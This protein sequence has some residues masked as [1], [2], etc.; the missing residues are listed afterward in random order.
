MSPIG[1]GSRD[2][3]SFPEVDDYYTMS[4]VTIYI[5]TKAIRQYTIVE[6]NTSYDGHGK[7]I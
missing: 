2:T 3:I 6:D 7:E 4:V 1:D 5:P